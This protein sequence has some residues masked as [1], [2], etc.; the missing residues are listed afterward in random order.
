MSSP[1]LFLPH[2]LARYLGL[3]SHFIHHKY[4]WI[5]NKYCN[6][7][8]R[9]HKVCKVAFHWVE[10]SFQN[11]S[12]S[13]SGDKEWNKLKLSP[14][15][16]LLTKKNTFSVTWI[17]FCIL[18]SIASPSDPQNISTERNWCMSLWEVFF[19]FFLNIFFFSFFPSQLFKTDTRLFSFSSVFHAVLPSSFTYCC[20]CFAPLV[21]ILE[22]KVSLQWVKLKTS[23]WNMLLLFKVSFWLPSFCLYCVFS[24]FFAHPCI[25]VIN[26]NACAVQ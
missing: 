10:F 19:F 26:C 20:V 12:R 21:A 3:L 14:L 18:F 15:H 24:F 17:K 23:I 8:Y 5:S 2:I 11:I 25:P 7:T 4:I 22:L 16:I 13:Q 1:E 9:F 6:G